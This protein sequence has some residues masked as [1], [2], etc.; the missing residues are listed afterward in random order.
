M[1][2]PGAPEVDPIVLDA[3]ATGHGV[4]L[5]AAPAPGLRRDHATARSPRWA[6]SWRGSSPTRS[7]AASSSSPRPRRC[8]SRRPWSCARPCATEVSRD[9]E[10][11]V[12]NGLYPPAPAPGRGRDN[13]LVS[14]WRKRRLLN[15]RE[16][17]R[18]RAGLGRDR[19][20]SC[21]SCRSTGGPAADRHARQQCL[22]RVEKGADAWS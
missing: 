11:L 13:E 21:P 17:A 19:G 15:D 14:L 6:A 9:P 3:P 18:L 12:V 16:L 5:L 4:R 10:A 20:S 2:E 8:R 1:G 22:E 7:A